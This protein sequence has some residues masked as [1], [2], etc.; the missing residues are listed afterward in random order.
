MRSRQFGESS[1]GPVQ[2]LAIGSEPGPVLEV[3]DLGATV[4]RLW[5]TGGDGA[6]RNVVLGHATAEEYLDS[7]D[8]IGGTIGRYAN[9]I[10]NGRFTLDGQTVQLATNERGNHLHGGPEGFDRQLWEVVRHTDDRLALRLVSPSGDQGSPGELIVVVVF[11]TT[12]EAVRMRF[13]AVTDAPTVVNLTSHAYFNLDGDGTGAIDGQLLQ[14]AAGTYLPVDALGVPLDP[15]PV[16]ETPF[17]LRAPA[18]LGPRIAETGGL[19][20]NFALDGTGWRRAATLHSPATRTRMELGTDQPGLQ[21]YTGIG[22]DGS[23]R[24]TTGQPYEQSAGLALEPQLFP[25]TPN[26]PE[27][28][29]AVLRPGETYVARLEWRFVGLPEGA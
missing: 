25:D 1:R 14:V 6:R 27:F 24:S 5:V 19:D 3:L 9:R 10:R 21:V 29:S 4:H 11:E 2:V 16:D 8:Y 7:V 13:E 18:Q 17:D 22:L 12:D 15:V 26:R 20:H 28:G 23:R